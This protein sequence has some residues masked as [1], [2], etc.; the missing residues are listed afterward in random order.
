MRPPGIF[1]LVHTR[2]LCRTLPKGTTDAFR[3]FSFLAV[4]RKYRDAM[5]RDVVRGPRAHL[6]ASSHVVHVA[7]ADAV[8]AYFRA[9]ETSLLHEAKGSS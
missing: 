7:K 1:D 5:R 3:F 2:A 8:C 9:R 6:L 4:S